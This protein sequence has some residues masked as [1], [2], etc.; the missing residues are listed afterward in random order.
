[1]ILKFT[2]GLLVVKF[3]MGINDANED[4]MV[5]LP[6]MIVHFYAKGDLI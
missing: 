1:M 3:I 6:V 4:V 5:W 2:S